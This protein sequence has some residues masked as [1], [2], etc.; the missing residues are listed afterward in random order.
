MSTDPH[1][2]LSLTR[3]P[4]WPNRLMV[5]PLTNM[6]SG[7][8]GVLS[9]AEYRWLT[10]RAEGGFG[11][12]STCASHVHP[13]G[14]GFPGQLGIW[15][16]DHLE[17]LSRLA[18]KLNDE[19]THSIVQLH[20]AGMRSPHDL[21]DGAPEC[22]SDHNK[23]GAKELTREQ[24]QRVEDD[25]VAAAQRAERAGF[26]GV[27]LHGAHGYLLCQFLS[28]TINIRRDDYGGSLENRARLLFD[29][30]ARIRAETGPDFSLGVRLSPERFGMDVGEI[31]QVAQ[32]L[33]DD[34]LIDYLDMSLWDV[35]KQPNDATYQGK[36]L[37]DYFTELE[38]GEVR[39][40]AAGKLAGGGDVRR[41]LELGLDFVILGRSAILHHDFP[42]KL[43]ADPSFT[44]AELP[45]SRAHL[46]EEGLSESFI[47]YMSS[48]EG[49][50]AD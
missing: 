9:D 47:Q 49:F 11:A 20:H 19:G 16:D 8:D 41:A 48:W 33:F 4:A 15:S 50:V 36:A 35:F 7:A 2:P 46:R 31:V 45:V 12:T 44:R 40:G 39:L 42:K 26:H 1:S 13:N 24:I 38:R 28:R 34:A 32:R 17:G 22:P 10:M 30:V 23:Y 3:G 18:Q 27:E 5:A 21:I 25:F 29:L 37:L 43:A 6:Q 14:I